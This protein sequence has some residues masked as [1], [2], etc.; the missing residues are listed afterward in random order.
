MFIEDDLGC[1]MPRIVIP[2]DG[3]DFLYASYLESK[4]YDDEQ[5]SQ[6]LY[7]V[8]SRLEPITY[9]SNGNQIK[10]PD[11][12]L[13]SYIKDRR[14]I[15]NLW[16]GSNLELF[17]WRG[18][19]VHRHDGLDYP[20]RLEFN[21]E[22]FLLYYSAK[23]TLL[24]KQGNSWERKTLEYPSF[25]KFFSFPDQ[26][27]AESYGSPVYNEM[28]REKN[29]GGAPPSLA[30]YS[31]PR[32][33]FIEDLRV[34]TTP[35]EVAECIY[36]L[37]NQLPEDEIY[38]RHL[39]LAPYETSFLDHDIDCYPFGKF[40][41]RFLPSNETNG[42]KIFDKMCLLG[43]EDRKLA[44]LEFDCNSRI[45]TINPDMFPVEVDCDDLDLTNQNT[46]IVPISETCF[47]LR[48]STDHKVY[49]KVNEIREFLSR[50]SNNPTI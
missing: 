48:Y 14:F 8:S 47:Y 23:V 18:E 7:Y 17:K 50:R 34:V 38:R 30:D 33:E 16:P 45:L 41:Y 32:E 19:V 26:K 4:P 3:L 25:I 24:R 2:T 43:K 20:L 31:S 1:V 28:V 10:V 39:L 15:C 49:Q 37:L 9:D 22:G 40:K 13:S 5:C 12:F 42:I 44:E 21:D 46:S 35:I 36:P 11:D 6:L 29:I 27:T